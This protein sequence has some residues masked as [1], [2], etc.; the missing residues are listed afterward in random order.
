MASRPPQPPRL[1]WTVFL[2]LTCWWCAHN[3][4]QYSVS[5]LE[6]FYSVFSDVL[7]SQLTRLI[8]Y[9]MMRPLIGSLGEG[10]GEGEGLMTTMWTWN[11]K[12]KKKKSSNNRK[13][14]N[15]FDHISTFSKMSK[16]ANAPHRHCA[17]AQDAKK[18]DDDD[19]CVWCWCCWCWATIR[20]AKW[21]LM[22]NELRLTKWLTDC[23]CEWVSLH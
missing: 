18:V 9:S 6:S 2:R 14:N 8:N 20:N 4:R 15:W 19:V 11:M 10:E 22:K 7:F 3:N 16:D 23:E 13:K 17:S 12:R 21:S 5:V 1:T